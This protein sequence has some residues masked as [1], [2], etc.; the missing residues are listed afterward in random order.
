MMPLG[1]VFAWVLVAAGLAGAV[2]SAWALVDP[3]V[4]PAPTGGFAVHAPSPRWRATFGL[5]LSLTLALV[6]GSWLPPRPPR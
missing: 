1:R 6:A 3:S 5:L 4:M 2:A